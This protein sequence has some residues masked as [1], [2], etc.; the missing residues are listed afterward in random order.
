MDLGMFFGLES[1]EIRAVDVP[2]GPIDAER[3]AR[4][5]SDV[6]EEDGIEPGPLKTESQAASPSTDFE[7]PESSPD[8]WNS[9]GCTSCWKGE[10]EGSGVACS[11]VRSVISMISSNVGVVRIPEVFEVTE[12]QNCSELFDVVLHID[13]RGPFTAAILG[14]AKTTPN[15]LQVTVR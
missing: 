5:L 15:H 7:R 12:R 11:L 6:R 1:Q 8:G 4:L 10:R 3:L 2:A 13:D 14:A 9:R